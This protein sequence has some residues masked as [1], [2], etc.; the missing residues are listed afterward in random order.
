MKFKET[1]FDEYIQNSKLCNLHPKLKHVINALPKSL[2]DMPNIIMH[3]PIGTGKYTQSLVLISRYSPTALKYEKKMSLQ[4]TKQ[5]CNI[6][7]SDIHYE[8]DFS[9]LGCNSRLIWN[10]IYSQIVDSISAKNIKIGIILCKN[11]HSINGELLDIFYSYLQHNKN[12]VIIKYVFITEQV[13][14][15]PNSIIDSCK[16]IPIPRPTKTNYNKCSKIKMTNIALDQITNIKSMG[17]TKL[18]YIYYCDR[19][20]DQIRNTHSIKYVQIRDYLYDMLIMNLD[21]SECIWYILKTFILDG[22]I[23]EADISSTLV[24]T[25]TMLQRYNNNY[26]PIMHLE[27]FIFTLINTIHGYSY[28]PSNITN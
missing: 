14:F 11:F 23:K 12:G 6:K 1:N 18:N 4:I 5:S 16:L 3:G 22:S 10:D 27:S 9:L 24:K 26:R 28:S 21:I 8:V 20:I 13:S 17:K 2:N 19:L 15:L 25:Y 7:L